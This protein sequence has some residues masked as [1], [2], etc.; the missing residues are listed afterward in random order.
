MSVKTEDLEETVFETFESHLD[1]EESTI[2]TGK[3]VYK[4]A[5]DAGMLVGRSTEGLVGGAFLIACRIHD[6]AVTPSEISS[7]ITAD[8]SKV[9]NA[10][11]KIAN[12][13]DVNVSIVQDPSSFVDKYLDE[14]EDDGKSINSSDVNEIYDVIEKYQDEYNTSGM[15][16]RSMTASAI[17]FVLNDEITQKEMKE[18]SG[19]SDLTIR[20]T[21]HEMT[22][23]Y[24]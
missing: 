23:M 14:L 5:K 16:P 20:N 6:E 2:S 15:I 10:K 13:L 12:E 11:N 9:I 19:I 18:V 3:S 24:E 7:Y 21:Y 17:Y 22:E 1:V 4:Q 8:K